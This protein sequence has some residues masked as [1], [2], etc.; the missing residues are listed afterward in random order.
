MKKIE[1]LPFSETADIA[2]ASDDYACRFAG[3]VGDYF[4]SV[5]LDIVLDYL[6]SGHRSA[7][8][9][10]GGGHGQLAIPLI[11][12]GFQLTITGSDPICRSRLDRA[13]RPDD[14]DFEACDMLDLPFGPQQ[15]DAVLAFR[16][17]AH[18]KQWRR[19]IAEL[20]R[21]AQTAVIV[22]YPDLRSV[23]ILTGLL[24]EKKRAIEKNTRPYRLFNRRQL[25]AEFEKNDFHVRRLRGEFFFPMVLHRWVKNPSLSNR[26]ETVAR[27]LGLTRYLGSPIILEAIRRS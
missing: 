19:L 21:V 27:I 7:I 22:D 26:L 12:R 15:F 6:S 18:V 8:L 20:C 16:L 11:R 9:D 2:T 23:N 25:I 4:L 10:V 5:Q 14:F 24:F 13:L 1:N 3:A 17:L